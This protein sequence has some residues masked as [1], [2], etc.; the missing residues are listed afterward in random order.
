MLVPG[1]GSLVPGPNLSLQVVPSG[2]TS[3]TT[4]GY[5]ACRMCPPGY[6]K[7]E[8]GLK[9][10]S[11]C[12][13]G[14]Y[15]N[16]SR[17]ASCSGNCSSSAALEAWGATGCTGCPT[18]STSL[19][20]SSSQA[21][22]ICEGGFYDAGAGSMTR[23]GVNAA[24]NASRA[25]GPDCR[26]CAEGSYSN[27]TGSSVCAQCP[28]NAVSAAGSSFV[29][30]CK[31][32]AGFYDASPLANL[33]GA[34]RWGPACSPCAAGS[35][36]D[37]QGST[38]CTACPAGMTSRLT[39]STS[40]LDCQCMSGMYMDPKSGDC[41]TCLPGTYNNESRLTFCQHCP[42]HTQSQA[43][44]SSIHDCLCDLGFFSSPNGSTACSSCPAGHYN[45][46]LGATYCKRCG[47]HQ[48]S[49]AQ[50]TSISDCE[51]LPG[52]SPGWLANVS[53]GGQQPLDR[54]GCDPCQP[55]T[56]K[57]GPGNGTCTNCPA[58]S[59]ASEGGATSCT[60]CPPHSSSAAGSVSQADCGCEAGYML[61]PGNGSL[62]PGPNLSLQVVPSGPTSNTTPG[63]AA[64]R[65]CPPGY[66][67]PEKGLKSCSAC[68]P[69]TYSNGS[70]AASCSGNC[71][72]SAALEAWGATGCTGCPTHSTSLRGSSSQADCICEG[73]FYDAG[74]GSMTRQGERTTTRADLLSVNTARRTRNRKPGSSSIHDCLCD[75]GFFSSPNGSTACSS[76]PAG[77]YNDELGATYCKRCGSHQTSPAQST[78]ISDCECLPGFSPGWL[79]N[80]SAGGQQPLDRFGCDPC[81]PG[82]YKPGRGQQPLDRYCPAGSYASEGGA[83]SCTACPPHSSSDPGSFNVQMCRC[84][85]SMYSSSSGGCFKCPSID[86]CG[87]EAGYMLVPGNGSL[88]PGPNL[89]LQV[90]PSGP[91]SNTTPGYA[92]CRMCPPGYYKPE[93]GLKSCSAC[94]PGTY[95]NGSRAASCSGNCSSS[96]ALEAWG[97]TG[98]TGCPTHSTSLRGS[99]SQADC[100]CEG[101]FYDAGA[102]S[103]T[104]QGVNAA[105]NASRAGGPDCRPCAEGSY[106][107]G[108]G[109]SVCAQCPANAVSAA[110]SSFVWEC[111]CHAGFYDASPLANLSGARRWG[112][113]CSPCA[114]GS[115]S[116]LQGSTACTACPAGMTSR[117]T[118]STSILD[119]QC[120]S[121]MYMDPK[122]GDCVTCLPGTYNNES[123]LTFCQHC[124]SHTQSQAGS[125]SIHDCLCDLGFFSSPNGSTAC[126]SC[127]AGHYNDEL[128]AT[129]CKRC[130][131]H[132]TSPAQSTSISDCECL[133]GFSPGWLANVSAGGQQPLDR[134][135]CDPCQPG[136]YKPGPGNGT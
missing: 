11:A 130:G 102:G 40:I 62:V 43:G 83:T 3:N 46:E 22:C 111:K 65:M 53:A 68:P 78:S 75:L 94:P 100:I 79:A 80:V 135:G 23:Q 55:G 74:A 113:A 69:G 33:S 86:D 14:T 58:G 104:R 25:G 2:P 28:A 19:R 123:R 50:S 57:P 63:Y 87:C 91:T 38:A 45:D 117:L 4:P 92:A 106:S 97:A 6:Y 105:A 61:V 131:S 34:R 5:A 49:P 7:P 132:Q 12:P 54:F 98:C 81:Q 9:S 84:I 56:Y 18:H 8:K 27:G 133:P 51:C 32:H 64:C 134:F 47:S 126:S 21:D 59:Y 118:G 85:I 30:E 101:G 39:G 48:T 67:K 77:H 95:S 42:S 72:S 136:T 26:P 96:A 109:S 88:V 44:S 31:C 10:C 17:A 70:R 115:Y 120:M 103:M 1:N 116:D 71:S 24:A 99:S 36:S 89:S 110:G 16:G 121:G 41:V 129:Y 13:P 119:C 73:G 125:S 93:K 122:S 108:T 82:T 128:G 35:Y 76:C 127:P 107:N 29:W 37:L 52:F 112:P 124:P 20:G 15:S 90:V 60:A 114:A 66:Y